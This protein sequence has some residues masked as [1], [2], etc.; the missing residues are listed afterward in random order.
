MAAC[1]RPG[2]PP[3]G[4]TDLRPPVVVSVDPDT[5]AV[6]EPG[7]RTLRVRF[8]ERISER[9]IRGTLNS[10]VRVA[11]SG[12]EVR[13]EH[14]RDGISITLVGGFQPGRVYSV[15]IEPVLQ[16]MFQNRMAV[17][18]EW[19]F[20]T[21]G[22]F[23]PNAFAGAAWDAV[24]GAPVEAATV[25]LSPIGPDGQPLDSI[26]W[27][28][29]T[30]TAGVFA[31]RYL[32]AGPLD[33]LI[34]QD[35]NGNDEADLLEPRF[36]TR[37]QIAA[38]DTVFLPN[39]PLLAIDTTA[40]RLVRAEVLDS[41]TLRIAFDD[42][43][44]PAV[45]PDEFLSSLTIPPDSV[46]PELDFSGVTIP[47]VARQ[48]H[49]FQFAEW[50]D[51]IAEVEPPPVQ[52][53]DT[54][55]VVPDS[56]GIPGTPGDAVAATRAV[57]SAALRPLADALDLLPDGRPK[58]QTSFVVRLAAPLPVEIPLQLQLSGVINLGQRAG[59]GGST[60][61]VRAAPP[62]PDSAG[63]ELTQPPHR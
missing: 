46:A 37:S 32:P 13:V 53:P 27:T 43:L 16:D 14:E 35:Q 7:G 15:S 21:G 51:S 58:P 22:E 26:P 50:L 30:D 20:S 31:L 39:V 3:G 40:A 6:V 54:G 52:D 55:S 34:W 4:P 29:G 47:G 23:Q 19:V 63:A 28:T 9:P 33:V 2:A 57:P 18:F 12:G 41:L 44:D 10:A 61:V 1:A 25:Q 42:Y 11:P 60:V 62:A 38:A 49:E 36:Q 24:T 59:G 8:N 45:P 48:F 5:F 56:S 17:P